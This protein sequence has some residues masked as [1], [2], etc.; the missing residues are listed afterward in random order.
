MAA[1]SIILASHHILLVG[2]GGGGEA[3]LKVTGK[4]HDRFLVVFPPMP[5]KPE[6]VGRSILKWGV[7][8]R[9]I[10]ILMLHQAPRSCNFPYSKLRHLDAFSGWT[11][12]QNL[13]P[14]L[15]LIRRSWRGSSWASQVDMPAKQ[16]IPRPALAYSPSSTHLPSPGSCG[17]LSPCLL[18]RTYYASTW[19]LDAEIQTLSSGGQQSTSSRK[20]FSTSF[21]GKRENLCSGLSGNKKLNSLRVGW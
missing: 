9:E 4:I 1:N 11:L 20:I 21:P 18:L 6:G 12:P 10:N 8:A 16:S 5:L 7:H 15:S 19:E 17:Q 14:M 13:N 2:W 3:S